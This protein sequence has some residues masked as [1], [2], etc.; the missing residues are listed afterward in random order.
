MGLR[1]SYVVQNKITASGESQPLFYFVK[2][3][4]WTDV[5]EI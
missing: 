2:K 4:F 1:V 5:T 3:L